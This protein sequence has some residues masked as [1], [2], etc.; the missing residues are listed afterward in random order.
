MNR[1]GNGSG[2]ILPHGDGSGHAPEHELLLEQLAARPE[3]LEPGLTLLDR[4]LRLDDDSVADLLLRDERGAAVVVLVGDG[5][6]PMALGRLAGV[7]AG[8]ARGRWLLH[9]LFAEAGL[10]VE[11]RP[12]FV[13]MA[14]RFADPVA[15]LLAVIDGVD[16]RLVEFAQAPTGEG[17]HTLLLSAVASAAPVSPPPVA[18]APT[19]AASHGNGAASTPAG[20]SP[21]PLA[22]QLLD[23][24]SASSTCRD[25]CL[26]TH[27]SIRSLSG[28]VSVQRE[29]DLLA[30][31]VDGDLLATLEPRGNALAVRVGGPA[32]N[33]Y[34][35]SD[36]DTFHSCLNA[37]FGHFFTS[38]SDRG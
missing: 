29:Q 37:V 8:M 6:L 24:L 14:G 32:G 16:L 11:L 13:L 33:A 25:L 23:E 2:G 28:S 21:L 5:R 30:F 18:R 38:F 34:D 3:R 31:R 12:R 4:D 17:S 15:P 36:D 10:E 27:D 22:T 1:Q 9:R 19:R 20:P 26:R 7:L 35:V